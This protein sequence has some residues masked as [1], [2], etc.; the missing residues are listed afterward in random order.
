MFNLVSL[1]KFVI[2]V[3]LMGDSMCNEL[4]SSDNLEIETLQEYLNAQ[5][6]PYVA[7]AEKIALAHCELFNQY[8][9]ASV[10]GFGGGF[11]KAVNKIDIAFEVRT[12]GPLDVKRARELAIIEAQDLLYRFN[13]NEAIRPFLKNYPM[14]STNLSCSLTFVNRESLTYK[15]PAGEKDVNKLSSCLVSN[16]SISSGS[17]MI[18]SMAPLLQFIKRRMRRLWRL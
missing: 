10:F 3:Q 17:I 18:I 15:R 7:M 8:A 14:D 12:K 1:S 6:P 2:L 16:G 5:D 11:N 4:Y 13:Q 9:N